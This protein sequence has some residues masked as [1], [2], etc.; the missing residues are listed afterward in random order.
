[1]IGAYRVGDWVIEEE[2]VDAVGERVCE[3]GFAGSWGSRGKLARHELQGRKGQAG[4]GYADEQSL[5]RRPGD[6]SAVMNLIRL[7]RTACKL[8]RPSERDLQSGLASCCIEN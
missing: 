7:S 8:A 1:M 5:W 3:G 2:D 4:P 6:S